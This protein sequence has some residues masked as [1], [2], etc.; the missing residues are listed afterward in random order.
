VPPDVRALTS[1]CET[2]FARLESWR[3][4][5]VTA[6]AIGEVFRIVDELSRDREARRLSPANGRCD[7]A[8]GGKG[9]SRCALRTPA[10]HCAGVQLDGGARRLAEPGRRARAVREVEQVEETFR[11]AVALG[12]VC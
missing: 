4:G 11:V 5:A 3:E 9:P 12:E 1:D 7:A 8:V 10:L 6:T 2:G